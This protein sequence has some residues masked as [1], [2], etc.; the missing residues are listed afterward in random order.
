MHGARPTI[1]INVP[2]RWA[3][4]FFVVDSQLKSR[5]ALQMAAASEG[6]SAL[7][8]GG[9]AREVRSVLMSA[10][11]WT[12]AD[13]LVRLLRPFSDAIHQFEGDK[14]HLADCHVTLLALRKL[15]EDWS[16]KYRTSELG[17]SDGCPVTDRAITT[18]DRRLDAQPVYNLAYSAASV[19]NPYYAD[20]D[21]SPDGQH[22]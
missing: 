1:E 13:R 10:D 7:P 11:Y 2:T 8:A 18:M 15:V 20:V 21:E 22:C 16:S 5:Q 6:C 17:D 19:L 12:H 9:K 4:K 3:T 14:P